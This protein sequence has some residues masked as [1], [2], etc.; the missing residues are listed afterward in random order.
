MPEDPLTGPRFSRRGFV[1]GAAGAIAATALDG[2]Q[3]HAL[4]SGASGVE[5]PPV[6]FR[7]S[8]ARWP[9]SSVPLQKFCRTLKQIGFEG[10]DLLQIDEWPVAAD[11]G[12][13]CSMGYP[14][15]RDDFNTT[16]FGDRGNHPM[17][18]RE[19]EHAI[20]LAA[21]AGVPNLIVMTGNR[22]GMSV[23]AGQA[24]CVEG[25]SR[26]APMAEQHGVTLCLELLNT[27]V[28]H[29]DYLG[30]NMAFGRAVVD[31]VGS[32]RLRL[33]YD[34]YH[35]QIMDGDVIRTLRDNAKR[36]AHF[37]T[38]GVPG[39]HELDD[40]QELNYRGIGAAI[41]EIGF[42]GFVAHEFEPTGE[43]EAALRS[44]RER[45]EGVVGR[46]L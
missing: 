10:V 13:V 14:A 17:L 5:L 25:L 12:L 43:W 33:L 24:A 3:L 16:G 15:S 42:A 23:E 39:R 28:D 35:M 38:G 2:E 32:P 19:L 11:A 22:R 6:S 40:R 44:A 36:I 31:G 45:V 41:S 26:I 37:H 1:L 9:F 7:Q 34:I 46:G 27:K 4:G 18:W 8:V 21:K 30:D 29:P 20:P